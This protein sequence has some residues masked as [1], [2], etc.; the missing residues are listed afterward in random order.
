VSSP[1]GPSQQEVVTA[2]A[3]LAHL[4][5]IPDV[6]RQSVMGVAVAI[7][8]LTDLATQAGA[9]WRDIAAAHGHQDPK[10]AKWAHH[11]IAAETRRFLILRQNAN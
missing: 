6:S 4:K 7:T 10:Y 11:H 5:E 3:Q 9:T 1:A 2:L 8:H